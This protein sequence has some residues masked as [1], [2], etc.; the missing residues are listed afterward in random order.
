M[1]S[2]AK[3]AWREKLLAQRRSVAGDVRAAEAC[4]LADHMRAVV[5]G[6]STV[7]AYAPMGV[8]PGSIGMLDALLRWSERVLLPVAA[9]SDDDTPLALRWGDYR[10]GRLTAGRFGLLEPEKPW[11]PP[12]AVA[13]ASVILVP[14]LAV[15]RAGVR[16]GRGRGFYDRSLV[17]RDPRAPLIAVVRDV[18]VLDELPAEPHDVRMTH[19]LTPGHGVITLGAA[20]ESG[21]ADGGSST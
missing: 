20:R 2:V 21:R 4:A 10:P 13:E 9:T 3:A 16:L 7:C 11:L 18:E 12:T 14:A 15:D 8:E 5:S 19:A 1:T 6:G 17:C